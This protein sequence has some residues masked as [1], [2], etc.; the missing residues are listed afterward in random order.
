M[1]KKQ[2]TQEA[3]VLKKVNIS[4][5]QENVITGL[6]DLIINMKGTDASTETLVKQLNSIRSRA[7]RIYVKMVEAKEKITTRKTK[8]EA[9]KAK[10]E[11]QLKAL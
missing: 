6:T 2:K 1:A 3:E 11:E 9:A 8:L 10:I 4:D 5:A 7:T